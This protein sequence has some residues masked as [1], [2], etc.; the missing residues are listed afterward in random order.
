MRGDAPTRH[1]KSSVLKVLIS[2]VTAVWNRAATVGEALA[3]VGGQTYRPLEHVVQDGGST[4]GTLEIVGAG[5]DHVRLVSE[6]DR[7]LYDAINRGIARARG[8]VIGL[9]HSDDTLA[10][11]DILER[12]A[13]AFADPRVD[14]VYGDL[15][16]V[17][18]T[19]PTRVIRRWRSE[20]FRPELLAR[21]W[22]PAHPTLFLR[23]RVF[24]RHGLYDTSYRIAADYDGVLRY[25]SQP[26]FRAVHIPQVFVKMRT[27]GASNA[28]LRHILHKSRED[29]RALK[30]NRIGGAGTLARKNFSKIRQFALRHA[31]ISRT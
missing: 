19:D 14:A 7:G 31:S 13:E 1:G 26:G 22:M 24:E 11:P 2:I 27:G 18:A 12:V 15:D 20:P 10:A 25:F 30:Q 29:Y 17:S 4:D 28:T 16:Y 23:R 5:G 9:V 6:P 21:G 3:S 8:E